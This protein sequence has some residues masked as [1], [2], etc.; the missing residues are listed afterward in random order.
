MA[1]SKRQ[2]RL[3]LLHEEVRRAGG[4]LPSTMAYLRDTYRAGR[5]GHLVRA[6]IAAAL[7]QRQLAYWPTV[8]PEDARHPVLLYC[9][10]LPAGQAMHAAFLLAHHEAASPSGKEQVA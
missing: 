3:D 4:V 9:L 7:R 6:D 1:T 5:L 10:D 8:L 2:T